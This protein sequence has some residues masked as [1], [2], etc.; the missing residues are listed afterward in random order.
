MELKLQLKRLGAEEFKAENE[1]LLQQVLGK[2]ALLDEPQE[3]TQAFLPVPGAK[4]KARVRTALKKDQAALESRLAR[5]DALF[6]EIGGQLTDEEART[7][8]LKKLNDLASRELDRYLNAAKRHLIQ[9]VDTLW[10]K[11]AV[12]VR[13]LEA[14]RSETLKVLDGFL[15]GLGYLP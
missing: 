2:L 15:N 4:A 14:E 10:D 3:V 12:S 11:Y 5:T 13:A 7:L 6:T 9:S 1:Q 8:V